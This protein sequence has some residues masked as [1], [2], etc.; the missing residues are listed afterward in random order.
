[1]FFFWASYPG[2]S[3]SLG[4]WGGRYFLMLVLFF[5]VFREAS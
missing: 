5:A 2:P 3:C 4:W 1:M